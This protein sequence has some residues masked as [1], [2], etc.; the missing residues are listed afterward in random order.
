MLAGLTDW[1][2]EKGFETMKNL[3][4]INGC[5]MTH[6]VNELCSQHPTFALG[7][8]EKLQSFMH[9]DWGV[10]CEEDKEVNE[11]A[12]VNGDRILGSYIV[13]E[14]KIWIIAEAKNEYDEREAVTVLLP[15]EY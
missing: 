10:L 13:D 6:G 7:V 14:T 9:N 2:Q 11:E 3:G 1:E 15:E 4:K 8:L 12:L 5:Y